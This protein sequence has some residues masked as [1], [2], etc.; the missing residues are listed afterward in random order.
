MFVEDE[1]GCLLLGGQ[2]HRLKHFEST[3]SRIRIKVKCLGKVIFKDTKPREGS[4][5]EPEWK[6]GSGCGLV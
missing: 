6:E 1:E 2:V 4:W 3:S 5:I